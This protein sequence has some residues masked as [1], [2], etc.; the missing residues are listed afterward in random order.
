MQ[1]SKVDPRSSNQTRPPVD[2][3][4]NLN[5]SL[6]NYA[7][8]ASAAGISLLA[9]ASPAEAKIIYTPANIPIPLNGGVAQLDLNNDG[10]IDFSFYNAS[11]DFAARHKKPARPPLGGFFAYMEVIPTQASNEAG[12]ITSFTGV[13]CAA[14]LPKQREIDRNKN[15]QPNALD[16]FVAGGDYTSPGSADCPWRGANNRG[17][18]LPLRFTLG[19]QLYYGWAHIKLTGGPTIVGYAYEN[20]AGTGIM[21]GAISGAEKSDASQA[22]VLT[23]PQPASLGALAKGSLALSVWR[24]PGEMN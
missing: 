11:G 7:A 20:V 22:P 19:G 21:S 9:L 15:W 8:A 14:E 1:T 17:G 16:M 4:P 13:E 18:F 6:L 23:S 2:L 5:K 12:A 3:A 10:V 24:R